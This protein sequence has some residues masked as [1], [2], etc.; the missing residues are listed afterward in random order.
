MNPIL[1]TGSPR[2]GTTW[3]GQIIAQAA[4]VQYIHEPFNI[5]GK[6]CSC[7]VGFKH[8]FHYLSPTNANEYRE[9]L[10]HTLYPAY[11][12][13][14]LINLMTEMVR[15]K[16]IRPL[17]NYLRSYV[18]HRVV[19][20]DP[21]A[22]FSVE[23]LSGLFDLSVLIIIRHPAAVVNSYKAANWTHPFSH[24]LDQPLLME[25]RL[26]PFR[27]EIEDFAKHEYDLIDQIAL[28]W[29][30]IH[31]LIIRYQ[32]AQPQWMFVKYEDLVLEPINGFRKIFDRLEL[33]YSENVREAIQT[34]RLPEHSPN[35]T[36][37]YSTR[38][39]PHQVL[40]KWKASLTSEEV[41]R[42]KT[43]VCDVSS[44]FYTELEWK[45]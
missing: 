21:L 3:V 2:S 43:R 8:W 15:S 11:S 36:G 35:T 25:E 37:M 22:V 28:L 30:L 13:A 20:K 41:N 39:N 1:V 44:A 31:F 4:A 26:A 29:K 32:A 7:G 38:Q 17:A 10:R 34:H 14:G 27:T 12:S 16:R 6:P 33:R 23:T 19:V 40:S 5:T 45:V 42:I 9:H 24:F 18:S